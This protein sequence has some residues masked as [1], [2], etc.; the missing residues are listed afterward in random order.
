MNDFALFH[1]P[2]IRTNIANIHSFRKGLLCGLA[3]MEGDVFTRVQITVIKR[4]V[5]VNYKSSV[6]RSFKMNILFILFAD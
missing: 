1:L 3:I 6:V 5:P 4:L 2:W